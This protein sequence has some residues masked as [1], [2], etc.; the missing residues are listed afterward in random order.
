MDRNNQP[1]R[2]DKEFILFF[3]CKTPGNTINL[4]QKMKDHVYAAIN[5][6][7]SRKSRKLTEGSKR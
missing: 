1:P 7:F 3:V 5:A 4:H 6:T 2:G